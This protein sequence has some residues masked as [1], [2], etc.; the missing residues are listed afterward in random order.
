MSIK[1]SVPIADVYDKLTILDIK[2]EHINDDRLIAINNEIIA[3]KN[4]TTALQI[5]KDFYN[6]LKEINSNL[7]NLLD[8]MYEIKHDVTNPL[9]SILANKSFVEND[10][11]FRMK[12][13]I[14]N[15]HNSEIKEVKSYKLKVCLIMNNP[16]IIDNTLIKLINNSSTYYD[17]VFYVTNTNNTIFYDDGS[18]FGIN[19]EEVETIINNYTDLHRIEYS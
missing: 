12:R 10:R 18:I 15:Y 5:N 19:N 16:N 1:I 6:V 4:D 17:N 7:F 8:Q 14:N 2:K 11:R 9:Y 3:L 13:K